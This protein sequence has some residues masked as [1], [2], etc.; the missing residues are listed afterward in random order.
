MKQLTCPLDGRPCELD[1]PDRYHDQPQGGCML[2]TVQ[3]LGAEILNFGGG[4]VGMMFPPEWGGRPMSY[5]RTCP[6]CGAN[7]DPGEVCECQ[8]SAALLLTEDAADFWKDEKELPGATNTEQL[9][10]TPHDA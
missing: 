4:N 3:E 9:K 6:H 2:T 10:Q 5:Y 1:C 7:L 8:I